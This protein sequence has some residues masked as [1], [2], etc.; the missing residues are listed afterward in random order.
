MGRRKKRNWWK[1]RGEKKGKGGNSIG[2]RGG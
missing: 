2:G 1:T